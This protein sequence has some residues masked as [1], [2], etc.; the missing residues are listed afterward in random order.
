M[1]LGGWHV[2]GGRYSQTSVWQVAVC[3]EEGWVVLP[4]TD[5]GKE[6]ADHSPD[7]C[8]CEGQFKVHKVRHIHNKPHP[9]LQL[10][11]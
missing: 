5:V 1:I 3:V 9:S 2:V 4:I 8:I 6:E 10:A 7:K 11:F